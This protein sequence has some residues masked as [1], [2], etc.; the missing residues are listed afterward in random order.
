MTISSIMEK[1]WALPTAIALEA[2]VIF[3]AFYGISRIPITLSPFRASEQKAQVS[4]FSV[5]SETG[6]I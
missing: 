1:W 3:A 6:N 5:Q 4:S 2:A